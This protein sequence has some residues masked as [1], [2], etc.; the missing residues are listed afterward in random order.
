MATGTLG[1]EGWFDIPECATKVEFTLNGG[2]GGKAESLP[3]DSQWRGLGGSVTG[4]FTLTDN[5]LH[6]LYLVAGGLGDSTGTGG[7]SAYGRGGSSSSPSTDNVLP[8]GGGG[9]ATALYLDS[10]TL[11]GSLIA[12]AG[13]GGG[14][15]GKSPTR[16]NPTFTSTDT[17]N[18]DHDGETKTA[19]QG[20]QTRVTANGGQ[21]DGTGGTATG[22]PSDILINGLPTTTQN[23]ADGVSVGDPVVVFS[24]GGGGGY[25]G[26]GSGAAAQMNSPENVITGSG[27]GGTSYVKM[28]YSGLIQLTGTPVVGSVE[29]KFS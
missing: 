22:A 6:R 7:G 29:I 2:G 25:Q 27:G 5:L 28:G 18:A 19:Q 24:G 16:G 9:G 20:G 1:K 26:G 8:G 15:G 12:V 4:S 11:A 3:S 10:T 17:S 14:A 13:G 21:S 23:G